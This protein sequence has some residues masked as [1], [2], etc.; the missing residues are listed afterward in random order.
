MIILKNI[1]W[2]K[3][4]K[5]SIKTVNGHFQLSLLWRRKNVFHSDNRAMAEKRLESL[6]RRLSKDKLLQKKY[7]DVMQDCIDKCYAKKVKR[8]ACTWFLPHHPVTNTKKPD[9]LRGVFDCTARSMEV[10]LNDKL[11]KGPDLHSLLSGVLTRFDS[12]LLLL[13]RT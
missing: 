6:K 10:S 13:L 4:M 8:N 1:A 11:L 7:A 5:N 3:K 9:K 12:I 2:H